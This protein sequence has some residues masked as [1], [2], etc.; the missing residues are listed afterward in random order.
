[1]NAGGSG[2]ALPNP[3]SDKLPTETAAAAVIALPSRPTI[4][5]KDE[6]LL[7]LVMLNPPSDKPATTPTAPVSIIAAEDDAVAVLVL[8]LTLA[9]AASCCSRCRFCAFVRYS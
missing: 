3:P 6:L 4:L 9:L 8:T 7:L 5:V 1:M 2:G